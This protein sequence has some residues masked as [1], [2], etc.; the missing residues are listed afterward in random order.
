MRSPLRTTHLGFNGR[1]A[2]EAL[3]QAIAHTFARIGELNMVLAIRMLC[4]GRGTAESIWRPL[5]NRPER[6]A[7][8][9][10]LQVN[11]FDAGG[12][13]RALIP[14]LA[15]QSGQIMRGFYPHWDRYVSVKRMTDPS[16]LGNDRRARNLAFELGFN[17]RAGHAFFS[18]FG[19]LLYV[20]FI[21]PKAA[22]V[23]PL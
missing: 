21:V 3:V 10:W 13:R 5:F 14:M 22:H 4:D 18:V 12:N 1:I 9:M 19:Q 6:P 11:E 16:S 20:R 2:Q 15:K 7:A 8:M 23:I 17:L